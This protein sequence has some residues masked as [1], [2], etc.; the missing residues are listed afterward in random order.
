MVCRFRF[1]RLFVSADHVFGWTVVF[2]PDHRKDVSFFRKQ[3]FFSPFFV[4]FSNLNN[5]RGA[6]L[7]S[8]VFPFVCVWFLVGPSDR[9]RF[10]FD[11]RRTLFAS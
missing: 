9:C 4:P 2:F 8:D 1:S 6:V 3:D 7:F 11:G 5:G 10:L